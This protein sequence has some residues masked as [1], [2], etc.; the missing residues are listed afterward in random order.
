MKLLIILSVVFIVGCSGESSEEITDIEMCL[1]QGGEWQ[2]ECVY[3]N[4]YCMVRA[5]CKPE[6]TFCPCQEW[7]IKD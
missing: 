6:A 7:G 4:E 1:D 2:G 5:S 3:A